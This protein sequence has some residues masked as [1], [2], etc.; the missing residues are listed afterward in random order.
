M[1]HLRSLRGALIGVLV[2]AA[3]A[4][5]AAVARTHSNSRVW[6]PRDGLALGYAT[7]LGAANPSQVVQ[8][9]IG[10]KDPHAGAEAALESALQNPSSPQYQHFLTPAQFDSRFGVSKTT[11]A[12]MLAWLR[13]GGATVIETSG[14][15]NY[16]E[17]DATVK[18][19]DSLF[20]T[21]VNRYSAH[22]T[23]FLA[24]DSA[25]SVPAHLDVLAIVGLNTLDRPTTPLAGAHGGAPAPG[26]SALGLSTAPASLPSIPGEGT[27]TSTINN[28]LGSLP[29]L[30]AGNPLGSLHKKLS[31]PA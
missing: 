9:G 7:K 3:I 11:F 25:P 28:V 29:G 13:G 18:Q 2:A 26:S 30:P 4:P 5:A 24:N 12:R 16:V 31:V 20:G 21:K 10:L 19:V 6:F 14:A 15:R 8:I 1:S 22:G 23:S 17:I 27:L